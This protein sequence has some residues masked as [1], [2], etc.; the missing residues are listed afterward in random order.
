[1][2]FLPVTPDS[3]INPFGKGVCYRNTD[4]MQPPGKGI[5][6]VSPFGEFTAGMQLGK[7]NLDGRDTLFRM[8]TDRDASAVIFN[9][10]AAISIQCDLD[11]GAPTANR[12]IRC[13][14]NDFRDD[15]QGIFCTG[16]HAWALTDRF[17]TFQH[18]DG[19]FTVIGVLLCHKK[20]RERVICW[21]IV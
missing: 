3:D 4:T 11:I 20:D 12:F 9:G 21:F 7:D 6:T 1:M 8:D 15:V 18:L 16:V 5:R 13:V 19:F 14:V 2:M 10:D 17:K